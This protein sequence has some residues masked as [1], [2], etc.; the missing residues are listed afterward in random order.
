MYVF[1]T[2]ELE[3][4]V[5]L[6]LQKSLLG[7]YTIIQGHCNARSI[8]GT[9]DSICLNLKCPSPLPPKSTFLLVCTHICILIIL[10]S[11]SLTYRKGI[12]LLWE[13]WVYFHEFIYMPLNYLNLVEPQSFQELYTFQWLFFHCGYNQ[14]TFQRDT[15][16]IPHRLHY[17]PPRSLIRMKHYS[18]S[19]CQVRLASAAYSLGK[20]ELVWTCICIN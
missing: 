11:N 19:S 14:P 5:T 13:L 16:E 7:N 1:Y 17:G 20:P 3:S 10:Y 9:A 15:W 8:P 2:Y 12:S 6:T 4:Q 18:R